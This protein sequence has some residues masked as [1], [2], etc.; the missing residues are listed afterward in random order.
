MWSR[1]RKI[2][3][4]LT[5]TKTKYTVVR[6]VLMGITTKLVSLA[7]QWDRP[8]RFYSLMLSVL[9]MRS[10]AKKPVLSEI[11]IRLVLEARLVLLRSLH[12]EV[13]CTRMPSGIRIK[14]LAPIQ[15][16][17]GK[18]MRPV[19]PIVRFLRPVR[20]FRLS[21]RQR[22]VRRMKRPEIKV[23]LMAIRTMPMLKIR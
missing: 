4:R 14:F 7:P 18:E 10:M 12:P 5:V 21:I 13:R 9:Q 15:L 17:S 20:L 19:A 1:L 16:L 23:P 6:P 8:E 22:L 3:G 2:T 11:A